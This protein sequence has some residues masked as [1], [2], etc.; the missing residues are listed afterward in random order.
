[1]TTGPAPRIA[2]AMKGYP[3]L[4]ETF[5]AQELLGLQQRG[6]AF[7]IWSLRHPTDAARHLMHRQIT[8]PLRYLPEYLHD[9]PGR[10]ARGVMSAVT[11]P[12]LMGF[13]M[14]KILSGV[15]RAGRLSAGHAGGETHG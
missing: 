7:E 4:S 3:R 8:A 13:S 2:V 15:G 10:V 11:R 14:A 9:E 1:M 5:I 6:V 12:G